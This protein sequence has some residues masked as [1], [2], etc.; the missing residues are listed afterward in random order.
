MNPWVLC[1]VEPK[2]RTKKALDDRIITSSPFRP[3]AVFMPAD[4]NRV[5]EK[6]TCQGRGRGKFLAAGQLKLSLHRGL[7]GLRLD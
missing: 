6:Q 1:S 2:I 5:T 7:K 4:S 3:D